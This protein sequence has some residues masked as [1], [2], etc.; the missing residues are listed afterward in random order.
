MQALNNL[1]VLYTSQGRAGEAIALLQAAVTAAPLYAEAWNNLGVAQR[2]I[3]DV[4]GSITSYERAAALAPEQ[5]NAGVLQA[6]PIPCRDR[7]GM[8]RA[9]RGRGHASLCQNAC[10]TFH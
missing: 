9:V 2:D 6:R 1:G 3:G 4:A 7:A 10:R 8:L 5:P